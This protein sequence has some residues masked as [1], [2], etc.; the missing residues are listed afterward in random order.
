MLWQST[1]FTLGQWVNYDRSRLHSALGLNYDGSRAT[2]HDAHWRERSCLIQ[3]FKET[4]GLN[5]ACTLKVRG[6]NARLALNS[7]VIHYSAI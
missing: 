6:L 1:S 5:Y 2:Y 4:H 7:H 3:V